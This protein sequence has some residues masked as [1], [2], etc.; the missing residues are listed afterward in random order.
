MSC[1]RKQAQ[2]TVT[3]TA[4]RATLQT[5]LEVMV[6]THFLEKKHVLHFGGCTVLGV[7]QSDWLGE[8]TVGRVCGW[9]DVA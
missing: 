8:P 4:A 6:W 1:L 9:V 7:Q 3:R 5:L 2:E